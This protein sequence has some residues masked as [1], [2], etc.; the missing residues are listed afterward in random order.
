M[1]DQS[2]PLS[3]P[4]PDP[5]TR[6]RAFLQALF[7]V[8]VRS[9]QPLHGLAA[10][11]PAPPRGRTL[12]LGAGKAA[13]AM[14]QALEALWPADAPLSGLVVTRYG[15]IPPRPAGVP[16]RIEVIEAAHPVPDAA[17]EVAAQRMLALVQE[18]RLTD[19]DLVLFLVSGG[20]SALL[21]LPVD[22]L[23]LQDKQRINRELLASGAN[24]AEMNCVRKHLSRIKGGR[25]ALACAPAPVCTLAISDVPGDDPA[26]IAS[27]PTVPD[28]STCAE[29]LEIVRRYAIALPQAVRQ[30][31]ESGALETPKPG[32]AAFAKNTVRLI[33]TPWQALQAAA[34]A[35]RSAG[36]AAHVLSD[37]V[38]GES[39]EVA[40]VHAALAR[41]VAQRGAPFAAP[42]VLLSGGETTVTVHPR[43][44]GDSPGRGGR[45]GEFCLALAQALQGAPNIWALAA[46]TD[47]IDGSENN[48]GAWVAPNTLDRAARAGLRVAE[49][50]ARNDSWGFFSVLDDLLVTGPTYTNVNDFR[51]ILVR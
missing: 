51:A 13:G 24:I 46:D 48:A 2:A 39:R 5:H 1:P 36:I 33:A 45:A 29:A 20:G 15:H 41:T 28:A 8:A 4:L 6:P 42:C 30:G 47:G 14:A 21:A 3:P 19:D 31:L 10:A 18:S 22:G 12:V 25:L 27:G 17:S 34:Q 43:A 23:T 7:E 49:H 50:L 9:A 11:L 35:A 16:Q 26:V 38:Q 37:E 32:A 40:K 44:A